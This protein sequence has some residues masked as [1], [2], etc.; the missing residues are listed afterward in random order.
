[1]SALLHGQP[2]R[3]DRSLGLKPTLLQY[4]TAWSPLLPPAAAAVTGW[5]TT[6]A[7]RWIVVWCLVVLSFEIVARVL[8]ASG[9]NNLWLGYVGHPV[10]SAALLWALAEWH[11][12]KGA[13]LALKAAIPLVILVSVVLTLTLDD[14]RSFSLVVTP[15]HS[16]VMLLA[17]VWTFVSL[18]LDARTS[19]VREDWF[20]IIGGLMAYAATATAIQPLAWYL[21]QER[22]DLLH[23]AFNVRAAVVLLSFAAITWGML[24]Q[25]ARRFSG[26]SSSPPSSPSSSSSAG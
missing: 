6:R 15:F 11:P 18:S 22:V 3:L 21:I 10:I 7:R 17:A 8:G 19:I 16:I 9:R 23:A 12:R 24:S 25:G 5:A 20:W 26:G 4:V 14:P 13:A 1:M 2:W